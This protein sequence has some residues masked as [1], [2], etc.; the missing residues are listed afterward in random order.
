M[1]MQ[2]LVIEAAI[3]GA[4]PKALSPFVPRT[5]DEIVADACACL[6]AGAAIVHHH[7]DEGLLQARHASAPYA[8]AWRRILE[9]HPDALLYPTMG[10]GGAHTN[11]RERYAHVEELADA[12]ALR[13]ALIDPG[14]LSL[15]GLDAQGLPA[16]VD[17]V[18]Q[19][20]FADARYMIDVCCA[21]QLAAHVSI[22]E[23]GFLRV[24][25]AYH[26]AGRLPPAK[27][28]FYFGGPALPFGLPA[29]AA[30]LDAYL[31]MLDGTRLPWM[32]GVI[33]GDVASTPLAELA[34]RRGGHV[35]VG[36]EDYVGPRTPRNVELVAEIVALAARSGRPVATS[37]EASSLFG[38]PAPAR[39]DPPAA[40]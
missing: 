36:L 21:R 19:N 1:S 13:M 34:I 4:T 15:G 25:L 28:Q 9:R 22:F 6:A 39:R 23:P 11:I 24:A 40:R 7:N 18:Y 12:G 2:P 27:I 5:P 14:S 20:S 35:R 32:V 33:G 26:A 31:A 29:T 30:S 3:N 8:A 10:G 16:P 38:V 17:L 37:A